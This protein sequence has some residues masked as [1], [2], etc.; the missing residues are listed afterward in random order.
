MKNPCDMSIG[1]PDFDVPDAIKMACC[2]YIKD[3]FNSYTPTQGIPEL[4]NAISRDIVI[5]RRSEPEDVFITSGVVGGIFLAFSV[6]L[7]PGDEVILPDPYYPAY[8]HASYM[9]GAKPVYLDTYPNFRIDA[10]KLE[11]LITDKTKALILNSPGNPTGKILSSAEIDD[12]IDVAKGSNIFIIS[13]EIYDTF[14][15]TDENCFS[16]PFGKYEKVILLNG[17]SKSLSTTGWRIGYAAGPRII[18]EGMKKMQQF[19]YTCAPSMAQKAI[20]MSFEPEMQAVV[21]ANCKKYREKNDLLYDGLKDRFIYS[22]AE[23]AFYAF[24]PAPGGDSTGFVQKA[25]ENELLIVPGSA[26]SE[27]DTHFRVS[28]ATTDE[29]IERGV[30]ILNRL[31]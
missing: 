2:Q 1:Q 28:F 4:V 31:A 29:V 15:Y 26:F 17:F 27:K 8:K 5:R 10:S 25:I 24:I 3:G 19:T 30:E 13:D 23:G 16:S 21:K 6:L 12:I 22:K 18:L 14:D 9:I 7:N 20:L 11:R